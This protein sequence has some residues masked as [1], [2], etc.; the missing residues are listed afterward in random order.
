M[1]SDGLQT[2]QLVYWHQVTFLKASSAL[3]GFLEKKQ[4]SSSLGEAA[5]NQQKKECEPRLPLQV[6]AKCLLSACVPCLQT[7]A[8]W[9]SSLEPCSVLA[10]TGH[11][12]VSPEP[13]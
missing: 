9:H 8:H 7:E 6:A 5:R 10:L 11:L 3:L 12:W 2:L 4:L 1:A 13:G